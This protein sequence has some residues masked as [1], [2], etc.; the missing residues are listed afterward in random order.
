MLNSH[1]FNV[2]YLEYIRNDGFLEFPIIKIYSFS[3]QFED[4]RSTIGEINAKIRIRLCVE[5]FIPDEHLA[6]FDIYSFKTEVSDDELQQWFLEKYSQSTL[7]EDI[8]KTFNSI[9]LLDFILIDAENWG[10]IPNETQVSLSNEAYHFV[11][12]REIDAH[13]F[14]P[15]AMVQNNIYFDNLETHQFELNPDFTF[16]DSLCCNFTSR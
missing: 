8:E 4:F 14:T 1:T 3:E 12:V 2:R 11:V 15:I 13:L 9:Q 10:N 7:N 6:G 5:H 16:Y